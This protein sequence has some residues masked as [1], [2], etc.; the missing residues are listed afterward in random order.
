[1]QLDYVSWTGL[2][3]YAECVYMQNMGPNGATK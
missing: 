3:V 2:G 1:M